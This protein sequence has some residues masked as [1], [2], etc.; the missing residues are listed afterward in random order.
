M[1]N[2][3][4]KVLYLLKKYLGDTYIPRKGV[5]KSIAIMRFTILFFFMSAWGAMA[6]SY[7]QTT[8]LTLDVK[9]GTVSQVIKEIEKQSEFTFVYNVNDL[10]LNKKVSVKFE[11]QSITEILSVL[12]DND[13]LEYRITDRHIALY[14]RELQQQ[15]TIKIKGTVTDERNEPIIGANVFVV[16]TTNGTVSDVN[17]NFELMVPASGVLKVSYIGYFDKD[18]NIVAEKQKYEIVLKENTQALDEVVVVGYGS[19]KK[20][21]ITGSVASIKTSDFN[22][23]NMDVT[24]VLQGRVAGVNV[25]N[26]GI[27][28]RG[29]ASINGSDP[30]WIVDGIPGGAP[31][32][33]D[34]ESLEILKDAASTA[35]YGARGAGGVILVTTKKGSPGKITVNARVNAGVA[36]PIDIPSMLQTSDYI[37]RK[38]AAG[39]VYNA[40][41]GWDNPSLLPNTNW[42]DYVWQNAVKQNYFVQVTGG[43]EKTSFNTS[44]EFIKNERAQRGAYDSAG[45]LRLS[46]QTKFNK[47]FKMTEIVTLGFSNDVPAL[48]GNESSSKIYY[49]QVPTMLPY[50]IDNASGGGWGKQP[51][52]GYYEGPNPAAII[53]S[54]HANNRAYKG[55]ANLIFDWEIIDHLSVQANL[56]GNFRSYAN[57]SFQ[58]YWST[59]NV[60]EQQRYTKDY[61]ESYNLRMLYTLTYDHMFA[62]KHYL[63]GMVGYEAYK[64]ESTSAGGWKTG[65]SV[66]P[67]EDMSLGSGSTEAVGGKGL[68]RSLSQFARLNYAYAD[69]YMVEANVRRDGYDNFGINNRFGIFPSA[70]VGWNVTKENFISENENMKWL[71][72]LK[73]RASIGRIGNNTVPQF[74]YEPSYTSNY[75]YYSYDSKKTDRGFWYSNIPNAA[76]KWE[77]VTQWNIGID[78]SLFNNRLNTTIEYYDKKTS[79]MLYSIGAPP[80]SGAYSSDIFAKAP[81]YTANIGEISNKGF[82]WMIQWRD[83]YNDF[84]YDVAFTLSTNKNRVIKLSDQINPII[85]KGTSTAINSSIYRTENGFPMGQM[86]GYVVDGIIQ[87]KAEIDALNAKAPNGLYQ[88]EGTTAGDLKYRDTNGDSKI[89]EADKTFIGNPWP[90]MI[91]GLNLNFSYKGFDLS[92]GWTANTGVDIFNSAK[93]YERSFYGDFNTTYKVFE[94]WS[95]SNMGSMHPRVVNTDPNNNFKNVSSYF[96]EDGSF[97]KLKSLHFGYNLPKTFLSKFSIQGLK[98]YVNCDNLFIISKFQGDP[99]IGGGYLQRNHYTEKRFPETRSVMGGLSLTI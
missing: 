35:I 99:E 49:R 9:N 88:E 70:S 57:N 12:F 98:F 78:A 8:K 11:N 72:Q 54:V 6:T 66:E 81:S 39:F 65:F 59:G 25:S 27:I 50:D 90:K 86:Y 60:S 76:I 22:D 28:I 55:G 40:A 23:L 2:H 62:D 42:E 97:L 37:D 52:G 47:R 71:S 94:A 26:G 3:F 93:V 32:M 1:N 53:G 75:L 96:V 20:S 16:G 4:K 29:A 67:V 13:A 46:S 79:D 34:I 38:K 56:S 14:V 73:L 30:L 5:N 87:N 68:S 19:Q 33:N 89:S 45:N 41:S 15:Y 58:E 61:G 18:V 91:F 51:A 17:G 83:S 24:N 7:S 48:Y 80:S 31:N 84:K 74:L 64:A 77:D 44:A 43:N 82:E 36:M 69:K 92:M 21:N 85:W 63:K 95:S 10:N